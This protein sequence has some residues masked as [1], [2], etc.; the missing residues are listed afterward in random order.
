MTQAKN[1]TAIQKAPIISGSRVMVVF[2]VALIVI[3]NL[4]YL[5]YLFS[6]YTA[7]SISQYERQKR[8][9]KNKSLE[10]LG[11]L[12]AP[13]SEEHV[14]RYGDAKPPT[15]LAESLLSIR[16]SQ[17]AIEKADS[18]ARVQEWRE[19]VAG[20]EEEEEREEEEVDA[21]EEELLYEQWKAQHNNHSNISHYQ[22]SIFSD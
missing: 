7:S 6:K 1:I 22:Y 20:G 11:Q 21:E 3:P 4:L 2:S 14:R 8:E 16:L 10:K 9:E 17:M 18:I 15:N 5:I 13:G 12:F 19:A